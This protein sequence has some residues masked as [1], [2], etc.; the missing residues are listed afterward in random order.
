MLSS[1]SCNFLHL[2]LETKFNKKNISHH[3]VFLF[4]Q[5][6]SLAS[7]SLFP[8]LFSSSSSGVRGTENPSMWGSTNLRASF[9]CCTSDVSRYTCTNNFMNR[10]TFTALQV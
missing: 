6:S 7:A 5:F 10:V 2:L 9:S 1:F 4:L 8:S 3:V